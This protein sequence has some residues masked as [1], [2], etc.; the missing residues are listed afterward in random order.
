MV[1]ALVAIIKAII[2]TAIVSI[3]QA[4]E[5]PDKSHKDK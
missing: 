5:L 3:Y 1:T 4:I 2:I